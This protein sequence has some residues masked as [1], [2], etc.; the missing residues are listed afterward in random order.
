MIKTT[1]QKRNSRAKNALLEMSLIASLSFLT[2]LGSN[3]SANASAATAEA[4]AL[5][6]PARPLIERFLRQQT[7]AINA[8]VV[9]T[10]DTPASGAL[11]ACSDIEVFLPAGTKLSGRVSVGV[12][13]NAGQAW[14]RFVPAYIAINGRYFVATRPINAGEM[15]S[16][17]DFTPQE[18]DLAALPDGLVQNLTQLAGTRAI[19]AIASGGLLRL[20]TLKPV[21]I[22]KQGQIVKVIFEGA[23]FKVNTEGQALT[24]AA[25]GALLQVRVEGGKTLSGIVRQD[26]QVE[27]KN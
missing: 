23:G 26:G 17:S 16:P 11:P 15:L 22:I 9:I 8:N 21:A 19:N 3:T 20:A 27:R 6:G 7:A 14:A 2:L 5:A 12:R 25:V 18:G 4:N 10:I 1:A 13:C 24:E